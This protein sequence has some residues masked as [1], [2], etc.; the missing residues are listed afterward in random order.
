MVHD[1]LS[2]TVSTDY[3][4]A[5]KF[6]QF[7][8]PAEDHNRLGAAIVGFRASWW[9]GLVIGLPVLLVARGL[10]D[11]RT[12]L[13]RSLIAFG[14]VALTALVVGLGGLIWA[15][16]TIRSIDDVPENWVLPSVADPVAFAR[17]GV[18]HNTSYLGGLFGIVT[19]VVYLWI[20]R[21]RLAG[22]WSSP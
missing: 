16:L 22:R 3:F 11:R 10:P 9:M 13:T 18:M 12:Y 19:G 2:Y 8:I 21:L 4:H 17:V 20:T 15:T 6:Q 14:V 1:Q 5:F 7:A